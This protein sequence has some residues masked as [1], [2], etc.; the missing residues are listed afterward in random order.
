MS[1]ESSVVALATRQ[2]PKDTLG[3]PLHDL[4]ISVMDRCNFRCPYCMPREQ[5]H[6][7]YRFLKPAERL[8]YRGMMLSGVPNLA[9]AMG[10]T[11][12][13][14]TL[15]SELITR[16]VCRMLNHMRD[17]RLDVCMPVLDGD[18]GETRPALDLSSGYIQRAAPFL[19]K[20]GAKARL[21]G[22]ASSSG[23][24]AT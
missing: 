10:Y 15:K 4:R 8:S 3:R 14:W 20:Q 16:Q 24:E 22:S 1:D 2:K 9:L 7:N 23:S 17:R 21:P 13:S 12:A 18:A 6:E 11:N 5:F 19:P